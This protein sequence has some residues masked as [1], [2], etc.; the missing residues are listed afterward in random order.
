EQ[1]DTKV[2]SLPL[3]PYIHKFAK[4]LRQLI[5]KLPVMPI[6]EDFSETELCSWFVK[7]FVSGIFD[8]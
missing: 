8:D 1:A 3:E 6:G 7:P 2:K 4:A 5:M